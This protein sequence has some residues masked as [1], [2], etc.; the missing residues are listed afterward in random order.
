[1]K[2]IFEFI[3]LYVKNNIYTFVTN[4]LNRITMMKNAFILLVLTGLFISACS[5]KDEVNDPGTQQTPF[6]YKSLVAQ[7][8]TMT[9]TDINTITATAAG[10]GLTYH[11]TA[12]Y[13]NFIG[14]GSS[15]Q[16]TVCHS[17]KFRITCEVTDQYGHSESRDVY[18]NVRN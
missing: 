1:M 12:S 3:F 9:L 15:V 10:D 2:N 8:T 18:V 16:W 14:S 17:D 4:K 13:G 7:D 5:K 11:W 6:E